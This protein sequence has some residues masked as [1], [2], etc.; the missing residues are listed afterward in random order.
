VLGRYGTGAVAFEIDR[1]DEGVHGGWSVLVNGTARQAGP[2]ETEQLRKS[3]G[4]EP[5]AGGDRQVYIVIE[6]EEIRGHRVRGW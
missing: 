6:P 5:W 2:H 1:I 3:L 4:L